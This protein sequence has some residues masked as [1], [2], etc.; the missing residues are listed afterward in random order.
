MDEG[1][2]AVLEKSRYALEKWIE[3]ACPI[4]GLAAS[5]ITKQM[6]W[7][8]NWVLIVL[9]KVSVILLLERDAAPLNGIA[10]PHPIQAGDGS[11]SPVRNVQY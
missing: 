2:E 11:L 8:M 4:K 10:N 3:P 7:T 1:I 5:V 9:L 6:L